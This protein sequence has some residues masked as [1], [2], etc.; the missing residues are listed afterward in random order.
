MIEETRHFRRSQG[1]G[2]LK[3]CV[4]E[5]TLACDLGCKHCGSRAGKARPHELTTEQCLGVVRELAQ[6]GTQE[7][8]LIGGEA[9]LR[10]DWDVIARAIVDAGMS[11]GITTGGRGFSEQRVQ[12]A[13]AAGID[14]ISVSIDGLRG[15]H[16]MQRGT[17]DSFDRAIDA[18]RRIAASPMQ[19]AVNTQINR[20]SMVELVAL[21]DLLIELGA[22]A[23]QL[24][25]TVPMGRAADRPEMIL[26]PYD[27]L[28]L[29]PLIAWIKTHKLTP[30]GIQIFPGN[31]IG[32]YSEYEEQIRFGGRDGTHWGGCA[33]G[34]GCIGV[35]S[36]GSIKACPSLPSD[37]YTGGKAGEDRLAEVIG[38]AEEL[39]FIQARTTEDLWGFCGDCY[40]A[41]I[42]KAGCTWTA[43]V[44]MGRPGNNPYCIHRART[45]ED[46][47][48][49]EVLRRVEGAAGDPFDHGRFELLVEEAPPPRAEPTI[50]GRPLR[51]VAQLSAESDGLSTNP[52][53]HRRLRVIP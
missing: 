37:R 18:A 36:D 1:E 33:A 2:A 41:E 42:C 7:V 4:W 40:Y 47:G 21:A 45:F 31:N 32:Y 34:K 22:E 38:N 12:R 51:E 28:E 43:H 5:I 15:T 52:E 16:N 17:S 25:L 35:E 6:M 19:L 27:L 8:T 14:G 49:R 29:F 46:Q 3:Y 30:A 13:V 10:E 11:C 9:Y 39:T 50:L 24:Q 48:K 23:W 53:A 44:L 20:L 26:Q